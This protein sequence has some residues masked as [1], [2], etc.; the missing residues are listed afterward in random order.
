MNDL[1]RIEQIIISQF[2]EFTLKDLVVIYIHKYGDCN[3]NAIKQKARRVLK[4]HISV[5]QFEVFNGKSNEKIYRSKSNMFELAGN[6]CTGTDSDTI[7]FYSKSMKNSN[8]SEKLKNL[9]HKY[10]TS[11]NKPK[12]TP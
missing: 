1:E 9:L 12:L 6:K 3:M 8:Q 10:E 5:D 2:G 7:L 11:T 4:K